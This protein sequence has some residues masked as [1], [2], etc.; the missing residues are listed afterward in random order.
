M[1][2]FNY[3]KFWFYVHIKHLIEDHCTDQAQK[4]KRVVAAVSSIFF[5]SIHLF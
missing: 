3:T 4:A 5:I 2:I 1:I